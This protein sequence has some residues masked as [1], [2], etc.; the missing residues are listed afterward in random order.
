[1]KTLKAWP[2]FTVLLLIAKS[3]PAQ[4]PPTLGLRLFAGVNITGT[5]GSI[6]VVQS[7]SDLSQTNSW[8]SLAF[9]QL[10]TTN[11]L[12]VDTGGPAQGNRFY[13]ALFQAPP[14]NMVF[15]PP[16]TFSHD[17]SIYDCDLLLR[18]TKWH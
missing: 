10:P 11:Y 16:N 15:I 8:A 4:T 13:R 17:D 2:L 5:V 1:M 7:T 3:A 14:T 18:F 12:F 6:Y 9:L